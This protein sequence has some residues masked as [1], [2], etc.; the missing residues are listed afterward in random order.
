LPQTGAAPP[1]A[2]LTMLQR[3]PVPVAVDG[4][5]NLEVALVAGH[6]P[7]RTH[8][9][10]AVAGLRLN[11]FGAL[12]QNQLDL[13]L[14]VIGIGTNPRQL[15]AGEVVELLEG[16]H[17]V[18]IL[19]VVLLFQP[20][21]NHAAADAAPP[22]NKGGVDE[23][24]IGRDAGG[25]EGQLDGH[26][27]SAAE[28][29]DDS[30]VLARFPFSGA[31]GIAAIAVV[32]AVG[33]DAAGIAIAQLAVH[34]L[35]GGRGIVVVVLA[36]GPVGI[37][38]VAVDNDALQILGVVRV[39]RIVAGQ[40]KLDLPAAGD[41]HALE[42]QLEAV[43]VLRQLFLGKAGAAVGRHIGQQERGALHQSS[44]LSVHIIVLL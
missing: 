43:D 15:L 30:L 41:L 22:G 10:Y 36:C 3:Q 33:A 35:A 26:D 14:E 28:Q 31:L 19:A 7:G 38:V 8:H 21:T 16:G 44:V 11:V 5:A 34:G 32:G 6:S 4:S 29:V 20:D 2:V 1:S 37:G 42:T 24:R 17:A 9:F 25:G 18:I 27:F 39:V 40:L 12:L 23:L 13:L